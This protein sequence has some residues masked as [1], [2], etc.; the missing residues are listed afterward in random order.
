[1][2]NSKKDLRREDIKMSSKVTPVTP[3]GLCLSVEAV[4]GRYEQQ[5]TTSCLFK[6]VGTVL[7]LCPMTIDYDTWD[8]Y[9]GIG[10]L[11]YINCLVKCEGGVG[12][13][14]A[15]ALRKVE[16]NEDIQKGFAPTKPRRRSARSNQVHRRALERRSRARNH[17][18]K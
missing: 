3:G 11:E 7:Y 15:G 13:A 1:M 16:D 8:D 14:G 5:L 6:G 12:W 2:C 17:H 10:K 18:W 9:P 4:D